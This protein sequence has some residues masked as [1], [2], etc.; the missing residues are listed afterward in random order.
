MARKHTDSLRGYAFAVHERDCFTCRYCG[1]NGT[2]SF[3]NWLSLSWDHLLPKG[4]PNRDN[5]EFIVTACM[6]CNTADNRYF[7]QAEKRGLRL[8][9]LTPEQL[10]EQRRPYVERTRRDYQ[11]FWEKQVRPSPDEGTR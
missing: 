1:L 10:V 8:C 7:D 9:G 2:Q 3:A 11:D 5:P 6:F 4:D